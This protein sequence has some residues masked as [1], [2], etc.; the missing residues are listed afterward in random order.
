VPTTADCCAGEAQKAA[1]ESCKKY[2]E[3]SSA[4]TFGFGKRVTPET[5]LFLA[6]LKTITAPLNVARHRFF[7]PTFVTLS[8]Y[9]SFIH[10]FQKT[11]FS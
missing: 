8:A 3:S 6:F 5:Y 1:M 2:S 11:S 10:Q 4:P 9:P 7:L